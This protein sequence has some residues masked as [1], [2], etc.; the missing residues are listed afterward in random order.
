MRYPAKSNQNAPPWRAADC[1]SKQTK[2]EAKTN[3][4]IVCKSK[5]RGLRLSLF[6]SFSCFGVETDE[7]VI[8][9]SQ[10]G[11]AKRATR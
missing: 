2:V 4:E 10:L 7:R 8:Y 9:M 6:V 3:F 1:S 5:R 11:P